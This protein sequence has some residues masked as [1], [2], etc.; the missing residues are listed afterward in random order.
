MPIETGH[1]MTPHI[2]NPVRETTLASLDEGKRIINTTGCTPEIYN[3]CTEKFESQRDICKKESCDARAS[4]IG[5]L[6][7]PTSEWSPDHKDTE[8]SLASIDIE[9][10]DN[11]NDLSAKEQKLFHAQARETVQIK[12][13]NEKFAIGYLEYVLQNDPSF[14]LATYQALSKELQTNKAILKVILSCNIE[15]NLEYGDMRLI[16]ILPAE[17][18]N[19]ADDIIFIIQ[20]IRQN[21]EN[22]IEMLYF[23]SDVF[24]RSDKDTITR[25]IASKSIPGEESISY[26]PKELL[27]DV[28]FIEENYSP[29]IVTEFFKKHENR[30]NRS[31]KLVEEIGKDPRKEITQRDII[32][33]NYYLGY[34]GVEEN[35]AAI[36][37]IVD[38]EGILHFPELR[39]N[40]EFAIYAIKWNMWVGTWM[41]LSSELK[42]DTDVIDAI[43]ELG[44]DAFEWFI[45]ISQW[46]VTSIAAIDHVIRI[47]DDLGIKDSDID[48]GNIFRSDSDIWAVKRVAK[49]NRDLTTP[50]LWENTSTE[51]SKENTVT[52]QDA[53]EW[54][55]NQEIHSELRNQGID[56]ENISSQELQTISGS[57]EALNNFIDF[58]QKLTNLKLLNLWPIRESIF[59]QIGNKY[60]TGW[61]VTNDEN[62]LSE[63]E[64]SIFLY[65]IM[66]S[67]KGIFKNGQYESRIESFKWNKQDLDKIEPLMKELQD[68]WGLTEQWDESLIN[69]WGIGKVFLDTYTQRDKGSWLW[70]NIEIIKLQKA[71]SD[72]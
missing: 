27:Y 72:M 33:I 28:R 48:E 13:M 35:T 24:R 29:L 4:L 18:L 19:N 26:L 34:I 1:E 52:M 59:T 38:K 30:L 20:E 68:I 5:E 14:V 57:Q 61:F 51:T 23:C 44:K 8:R 6:D 62:Y 64:V 40:K 49:N 17:G 36:K 3:N 22:G 46:N 16:D 55:L 43:S 37:T 56:I 32:A 31:K 12:L 39:A 63:N 15:E 69:G 60:D 21:P 25:I 53:Q 50:K 58:H 47:K 9:S 2:P 66:Y 54:I 41:Y 10:L 71:I 11:F 42:N 67:V 65:T 70:T 45:G 7:I